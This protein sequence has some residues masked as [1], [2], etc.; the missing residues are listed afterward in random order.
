M[1]FLT[2]LRKTK[3]AESVV[4]IDIGAESVAGAYARYM[5]GEIPTLLYTR[6]LPIEIR[7]GE[8]HEAAMLRALLVLGDALI[9]EGAPILMRATGSGN[10]HTILVSVDTP[11]QKTSVRT[12]NFERADPFVLT[13]SMVT[14]AMQETSASVPGKHLADDSIIGTILNGYETHNPYGRKVRRASVIVLSSLIDEK[15]ADGITT[16][17]RGLFHTTNILSIAG[18]SLRYQAM[19]TAFPHEHDALI[20]DATGPAVSIALVRRG[21]FIDLAEISNASNKRTWVAK[22]IGEFAAIAEKYPLPRVIFLLARESD[23]SLLQ[24]TLT[25]MNL[26]KLWLSDN[27]PKIVS[28]LAS[29]LNGL[30]RQSTATPPDLQLLLMA[31]YYQHRFP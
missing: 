14:T 18:S 8:P 12:E 3:K 24:Q 5:E 25:E 13:K 17:L 20:L 6:R 7:R 22:V 16:A 21:L 30:V 2:F 15:I 9:R 29:H 23:I 4:L 11:W 19:R 1:S 10:A 28:V 31:L 27:P 26:E